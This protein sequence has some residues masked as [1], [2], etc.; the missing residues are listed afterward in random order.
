MDNV[1]EPSQ[2]Q[3]KSDIKGRFFQYLMLERA[4]PNLNVPH[5]QVDET[6]WRHKLA[7]EQDALLARW[8]AQRAEYEERLLAQNQFLNHFSHHLTHV[9]AAPEELQQDTPIR[10]EHFEL[11]DLLMSD[12]PDRERILG[13]MANLSWLG[14]AL[15]RYMNNPKRREQRRDVEFNDYRLVFHYLGMEPLQRVLPWL[16]FQH[17]GLARKEGLGLRQRKLW[18]FARQQSDA[19]AALARRQKLSPNKARILALMQCLNAALLLQVGAREFTAMKNHWLSQA[20]ADGAKVVHQALLP[21]QLPGKP[22]LQLMKLRNDW[23]QRLLEHWQLTDLALYHALCRLNESPN[24]PLSKAVVQAEAIAIHHALLTR[25]L[26]SPE[27]LNQWLSQHQLS[28]HSQWR[29]E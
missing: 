8:Q 3:Q 19:A 1:A 18:R 21:L 7:V 15:L 10:P 22:L 29:S 25:R 11:L 28:R 14:D 20:R 17:W 6:L 5:E 4:V 27:E 2:S 12:N 23:S 9:L 24:D 16:I 26:A 13:H